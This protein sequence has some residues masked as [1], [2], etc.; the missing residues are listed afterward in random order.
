LAELFAR[1]LAVTLRIILRSPAGITPDSICAAGALFD[2]WADDKNRQ[3][4][5]VGFRLGV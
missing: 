5:L 1:Y 3:L 4:R 2:L